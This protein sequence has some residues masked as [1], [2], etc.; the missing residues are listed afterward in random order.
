VSATSRKRWSVILALL[1]VTL[2]LVL[3]APDPDSSGANVVQAIA[4]NVAASDR[5]ALAVSIDSIRPR[6][7]PGAAAPLFPAA[8]R[9][10]VASRPVPKPVAAPVVETPDP[11]PPPLPFKT[12]GRLDDGGTTK[13]FVKYGER[14]LVLS[15]GT[16][17]DET[18]EVE[19][20]KGGTVTFVYL[21]LNKTQT[22]SI[23]ER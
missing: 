15:A 13:V 19:S 2:V 3:L 16:R 23:G 17:I 8:P 5:A 20:I 4:P 9:P 22:F 21:P 10:V 7:Q 14:D 6:A 12:L 11:E 18:Y 1:A